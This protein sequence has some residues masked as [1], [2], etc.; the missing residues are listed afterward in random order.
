MPKVG[1]WDGPIHG[2]LGQLEDRG[3][4]VTCH[5]CG[6]AYRSLA[7][8]IWQAHD[9]SAAEYRAF[10]G[11]GIQRALAAGDLRDLLAARTT[12][13]LAEGRLAVDVE[14]LRTQGFRT[15]EQAAQASERSHSHERPEVDRSRRDHGSRLG[16]RYGIEAGFG[17][18]PRSESLRANISKALTG[19][20]KSE[21]HRRKI[22]AAVRAA[23]ARKREQS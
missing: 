17:P 10:F 2:Q 14:R 9:V 19:K 15:S 12:A 4:T 1:D 3:D 5:V 22:S 13:A 6:G 11:L 23:H 21:E 8:H 16:Q 7:S 18:G 20:P